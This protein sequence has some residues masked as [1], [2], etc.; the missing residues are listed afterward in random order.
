MA[1]TKADL[2]QSTWRRHGGAGG[3][4]GR[5]PHSE[6]REAS[7]LFAPPPIFRGSSLSLPCPQYINLSAAI[8]W[9]ALPRPYY[10]SEVTSGFLKM[11]N[12][13]HG[14]RG[15]PSHTLPNSVALLPRMCGPPLLNML[16]R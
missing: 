12:F 1:I 9:A 14:A 15:N 7:T 6:K 3:E 8:P 16:L 10:V 5:P 2:S 4:G 13:P 11:K